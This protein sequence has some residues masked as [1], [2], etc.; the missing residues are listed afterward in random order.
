MYD[1]AGA[2]DPLCT[3]NA[4]SGTWALD[5]LTVGLLSH[6]LLG[7]STHVLLGL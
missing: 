1:S 7:L 5:P 4:A 2:F 6:V 3:W